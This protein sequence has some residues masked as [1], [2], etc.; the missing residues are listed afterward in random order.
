MLVNSGAGDEASKGGVAE[1][2]DIAERG[3]NDVVDVAEVA[4]ED[5]GPERWEGWGEG[6]SEI[7]IGLLNDEPGARSDTMRGARR[8]LLERIGGMDSLLISRFDGEACRRMTVV[9]IISTSPS[10]L[11]RLDGSWAFFLTLSAF[12]IEFRSFV[13]KYR[14]WGIFRIAKESWSS[15]SLHSMPVRRKN[16]YPSVLTAW[17]YVVGHSIHM[18]CSKS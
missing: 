7:L 11:D 5:G 12:L 10:E 1:R 14:A 9:S 3:K 17:Q 6:D 13:M 15:K 8:G 18:G 16:R 4:E 2:E